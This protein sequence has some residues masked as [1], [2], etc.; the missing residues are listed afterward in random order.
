MLDLGPAARQMTE[1][2]GRV[3]DGHLTAP[4]PCDEYTLGDLIDHVG[5]LS[6]AFTAAA[7]KEFG[8]GVLQGP[9]GDAARLSKDWRTRIPG[10]LATLV[11]AWRD[12][13]A[14][15][16][17]TRAGGIDLPAEVAG[18]V[19][20]NELVIHG[21]DVARTAGQP[22]DCDTQALQACW[23]LLADRSTADQEAGDDPFGPV[24]ELPADAPLLDRLIGLS[25]RNPTW[26]TE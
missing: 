11:E 1:L 4:T 18:R 17:M 16:G 13:A 25:G 12:P 20:L 8:P 15:Q 26:T 7:R 10:Q 6:R 19:A 24:V 3:T 22:F 23:E 2:L 9:S 14:W 21:W 5:G